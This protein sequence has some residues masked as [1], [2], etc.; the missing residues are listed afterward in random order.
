MATV[1]MAFP[2]GTYLPAFV[3]YNPSLGELLDLHNATLVGT[4]TATGIVF[5]LQNGLV[6]RLNGT[7]FA[8]DADGWATAGTLTDLQLFREDGTTIQQTITGLSLPLVDVYDSSEAYQYDD[9]FDSWGFNQWLMKGNDTIN[10]SSGTDDIY[11]HAGNDVLKGNAGDDIIDGGA[12]KDSC[13]G[14]AGFDQLSFRSTYGDQTAIRGIVLD[15]TAGTVVD[16]WGNSETFTGFEG[17]RGTQFADTLNGS[18]LDEQFMG[19]GGRDKIDG[20]GGLD[21]VR[22]DRDFSRGGNDGVTVNL[23]TGVAVD[24]FGRQD[25][26]V[27]IERARG[28]DADDT[29]T[30]NSAA[31]RFRGLGGNDVLDGKAGADDMRGGTGNDTYVV[32]NSGDIVDENSDG[33]AG[34]DTVKSSISF[35]LADTTKVFGDVERLTL[36]GSSAINGSGNS[37]GNI[38]T[39]NSA[40]NSLAGSSGNDTLSG[41]SG[42]DTLNGGSGKDTLTGGAGKDNFRFNTT[43]SAS[44][45]VDTVTDFSVADD[46]V[47]LDNVVF[48]ALTT[49]GTLASAAFRANTTGLAG[50]SS[51]RIIY[52]SDT[53]KLFYDADG[54]GATVGIQFAILTAGLALTNAD[55]SVI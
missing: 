53:G 40:N 33:G 27:G 3:D 44:G 55:F 22:Y 54:T 8:L 42:D 12:G 7:G 29:F 13:D 48:T 37:L 1:T 36:T 51:D 35:N 20:K 11:G 5:E 25:T 41:G 15:A 31:N 47:Q 28:T 50:D 49:T 39:G 18:S 4:P 45:N 2:G 9:G 17:F 24:G 46:T 19:L 52:E 10:G 38:I 26:L 32:D 6:L 14:G 30:G 43:L 34:T 23:T 16:P 21:E